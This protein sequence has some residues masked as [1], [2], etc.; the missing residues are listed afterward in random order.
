M[1]AVPADSHP[2]VHHRF[3][4]LPVLLSIVGT[5]HLLALLGTIFFAALV[6]D[7]PAGLLVLSSRNRH[8]LLAVPAGIS[9]VAFFTIAFVRLTFPAVPYYVLGRRY[10]DTGLRWLEREAGGTPATIRWVERWF[11]RAAVPVVLLMPASNI[12]SVLAGHRRMRLRLFAGLIVAG[13][14]G[15]LLFFWFLGRALREPLEWLLD[16]IQ[17]Y[18]WWI[19]AAFFVLSMAQSFRQVKAT[20]AEP[21]PEEPE[22]GWP[23]H[24]HDPDR[25]HHHHPD[26]PDD[27]DDSTTDPPGGPPAGDPAPR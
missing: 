7:A 19:V 1:D 17:R 27:R 22:D 5:H 4:R 6:N 21:M 15:R 16:V 10:G 9:A 25:D 2:V 3:L 26:H 24:D 11:D 13:V 20:Q 18:Q 14:V 8:L 23:D 12:V